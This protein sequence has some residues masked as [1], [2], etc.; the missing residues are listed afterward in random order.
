MHNY[1]ILN[2]NLSDSAIKHKIISFSSHG[3]YENYVCAWMAFFLNVQVESQ[4]NSRVSIKKFGT[5]LYQAFSLD[6]TFVL[7]NQV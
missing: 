5:Q 6:N 1:A 4:E 7:A 3:V 2:S